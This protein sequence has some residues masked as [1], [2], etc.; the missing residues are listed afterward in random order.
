M[1]GFI[2]FFWKRIGE[3]PDYFISGLQF[4]AA[5]SLDNNKAEQNNDQPILESKEEGMN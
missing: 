3:F 5:L 1:Q 4:L 2:I